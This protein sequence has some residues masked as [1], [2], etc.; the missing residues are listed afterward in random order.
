MLTLHSGLVFKRV[1]GDVA[2]FH[3]EPDLIPGHYGSCCESRFPLHVLEKRVRRLALK[4]PHID[5]RQE[6]AGIS[7][8]LRKRK[9]L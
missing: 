4:H 8:L 6:R 1:Q 2:V 5:L 7:A 9:A 3:H